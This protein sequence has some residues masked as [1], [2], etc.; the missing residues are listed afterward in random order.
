MYT[1]SF[2]VISQLLT[3]G[4]FQRAGA[5]RRHRECQINFIDAVRTQSFPLTILDTLGTSASA[6]F[7]LLATLPPP[8]RWAAVCCSVIGHL[9]SVI[10]T[11]LA[12]SLSFSE[13]REL[14]EHFGPSVEGYGNV[15]HA[16]RYRISAIFWFSILRLT[17]GKP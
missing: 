6:S 13:A 1:S 15:P 7:R 14:R 8:T 2:F 12:I 3:S 9:R 16:I 4:E 11:E 17:L 10:Q 5:H